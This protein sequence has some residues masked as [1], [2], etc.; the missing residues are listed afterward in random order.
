MDFNGQVVEAVVSDH[1]EDQLFLQYAGETMGSNLDEY[2]DVPAN[3]THI[4][5]FAYENEHHDARFTTKMPTIS[6]SEYSFCEVVQVRKDLGVFVDVGLPDKD[7]VVSMDDLPA[8]SYL[9][10]ARGDRLLVRLAIDKKN[11]LWGELAPANIFQQ[12]AHRAS[13]E[14][15]NKDVEATAYL[16]KKVGTFV[17]T[18]DKYIGFIHPSERDAEPR[19]GQLVKAR[20]IGVRDDGQLNL[21]MRPRA[22]EAID[23]DAAMLMAMLQHSH[24]GTLWL[25]DK[26]SPEDIKAQLDISKGAFKRAVGHLLKARLIVE[27]DGHLE[28]VN[29]QGDAGS[30]E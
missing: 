1:N 6:E 17:F 21:S 2:A 22:Y 19:L 3:G 10:P 20:V 14:M 8:E 18:S 28:L 7:I 23:D 4:R 9:W 13:D 29:K 16:L 30:Q 5:G 15:Q 25:S 11:R 26:S 27:T 24:D 12:L